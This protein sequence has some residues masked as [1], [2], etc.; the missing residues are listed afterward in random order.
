M[1]HSTSPRRARVAMQP[2]TRLLA[3]GVLA[4]TMLFGT[5]LI[6]APAGA[7]GSA[8]PGSPASPASPAACR[9]A[10]AKARVHVG[11]TRRE[12]TLAR[13]VATLQARRDPWSLNGAQISALQ[14][15]NAGISAL[16]YG[17]GI[18]HKFGG[19]S[20][21]PSCLDEGLGIR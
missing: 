10:D 17:A 14:N 13:L 6:A 2:A 4:G 16:V 19:R 3:A 8:S 7:L 9:F 12:A 18:E 5:G 1:N 11:A 20:H 21:S 15:A